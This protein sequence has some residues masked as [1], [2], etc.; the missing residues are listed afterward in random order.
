MA[1]GR[2]AFADDV[3]A[4]NRI[5]NLGHRLSERFIAE[6]GSTQCRA[7]TQSD[8]STAAGARHFVDS[9]GATKCAVIART[10]A[11]HVRDMIETTRA[12]PAA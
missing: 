11:R 3:N 2:D 6:F 1:A 4:F 8:F 7:I 12:G 5:M 10:V 9:D